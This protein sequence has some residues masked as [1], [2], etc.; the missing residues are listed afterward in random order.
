MYY[1]VTGA[2]GMVGSNL[3]KALNNRGIRNVIAVDNLT[4][5]E[6]FRN[7][8][9]CD[10]V[11]FLDKHDFIERVQ[12]GHFDG[13]VEAVLHFGACTDSAVTDG[14]YL[15]DNNYRYGLI[16]L[17]WCLDQDQSF[18]Y[19]SSAAVYGQEGL[20]SEER[21]G[22]VPEDIAAY[23]RLLFDRVVAQRLAREPSSLVA[24]LRCFD[25]YGPG[26]AHKGKDASFVFGAWQ[27]SATTGKVELP[28]TGS[29]EVERD[30][31]Y[32]DDVVNVALHRLDHP[33]RSGLF[34]V[35]TGHATRLDEVA[36]EV[37]NAGRRAKGEAALSVDALRAHDLLGDKTSLSGRCAQSYWADLTRLRDA[38]Y[39][40]P[41][42]SLTDGIS[43]YV[44]WLNTHV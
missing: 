40:A 41:M 26:E 29:G 9:D 5:G 35:G 15:L 42:T 23:S 38:G 30:F 12:A 44:N 27:Q 17:D 11:D 4:R 16:L 19:A 20:C 32:V 31:I 36:A 2:A 33:E 18:I 6:K 3:V 22:E 21:G 43:K 13:D 8:I 25:V 24:G 34:N 28:G 37:I 14:R 1:V 10:I 39:D 7:L